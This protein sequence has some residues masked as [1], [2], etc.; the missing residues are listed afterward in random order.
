MALI[1]LATASRVKSACTRKRPRPPSQRHRSDF[2]PVKHRFGESTGP[3]LQLYLGSA[4]FVR[5][6]ARYATS[7]MGHQLSGA[8]RY[9]GRRAE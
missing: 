2:A 3:N 1:F 9:G 5:V 6:A 7:S 8:K 4:N